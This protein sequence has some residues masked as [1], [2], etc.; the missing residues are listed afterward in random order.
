[1]EKILITAAALILLI[2]VIFLA[3]GT[4]LKIK[5]E[6]DRS[7]T[8]MT[9]TIYTYSNKNDMNKVHPEGEL[10]RQS[11]AL[12]Y[13]NDPSECEIHVLEGERIDDDRTMTWGH[14]LQHCIYGRFHE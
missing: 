12:W 8:T 9:I 4:G 11:W 3:T 14:E 13:E 5:P 6:F 7:G 2:I 10:P 1:M